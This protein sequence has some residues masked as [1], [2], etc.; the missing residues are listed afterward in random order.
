MIKAKFS[1]SIV[2]SS[3]L[4]Y[5][6]QCLE[7][8]VGVSLASVKY[9]AGYMGRHWCIELR[10]VARTEKMQYLNTQL[11]LRKYGFE[12]NL[13]MTMANWTRN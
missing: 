11:G 4:A 1:L 2:I 5:S 12:S 6:T 10:S 9:V 3:Y 8:R 13:M 7:V